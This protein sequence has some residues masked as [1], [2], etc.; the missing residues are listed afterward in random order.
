MAGVRSCQEHVS[1]GRTG[2][3][4]PGTGGTWYLWAEASASSS[5]LGISWDW[6]RL[7]SGKG[8]LWLGG[9]LAPAYWGILGFCGALGPTYVSISGGGSPVFI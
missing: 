8:V 6:G 1:P 9:G 2:A 7:L 3:P 5:A 4:R